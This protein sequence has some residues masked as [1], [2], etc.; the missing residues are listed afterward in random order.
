MR[1]HPVDPN[2]P[3]VGVKIPVNILIV[4]DFPAPFF[5]MYPIISPCLTVNE[6]SS[7]A[8]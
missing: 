6:I 2:N 8:A 7:T 5:P 1:I 4:A 3:D